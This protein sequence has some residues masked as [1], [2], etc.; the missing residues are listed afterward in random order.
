MSVIE[1]ASGHAMPLLGLGTWQLRGDE[2]TR[3]VQMALE[4][5]NQGIWVRALPDTL[6]SGQ[7][8]AWGGVLRPVFSFPTGSL[9]SLC[10][11]C[12]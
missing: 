6:V 10:S 8:L 12:G 9:H 4:K 1:L 3:V 5:L 11:Q 7:A 2:C